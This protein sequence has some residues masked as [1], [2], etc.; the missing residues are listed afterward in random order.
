MSPEARQ[1]EL[2]DPTVPYMTLDI[3]SRVLEL[4]D[5]LPRLSALITE[6]IREL[7]GARFVVLLQFSATNGGAHKA[8]GVNPARRADICD[9]RG[10]GVLVDAVRALD[11]LTVWNVSD[12]VEPVAEALRAL[13]FDLNLAVPLKAGAERVGALL[14]LGVPYEKKMGWIRITINPLS[15]VLSLILRNAFLIQNQ[16]ELINARTAALRV[17]EAEMRKAKEVAEAANR[18]KSEFLATMSH[19]L[20]TPLNAVIG[21]TDLSLGTA[22]NDEQR[23]F[24]Q[25]VYRRSIDLL[26]II[27]DIL[28]LVKIET[29]RLDVVSEEIDVCK[30]VAD[31]VETIELEAKRKNL[32]CHVVIDPGVPAILLGDSLRLKQ[33]LVNLLG[34]AVKF[35][36]KGEIRLAVARRTADLSD[37]GHVS[38]TS[39]TDV[40]LFTVS[41]TGIGIS[42]DKIGLVFDSFYQA[43]SSS[44]RKFG[45]VGLGLA[46]CARLIE[47]MGG[48]I[49]VESEVGKGSVFSFRLPLRPTAAPSS[50]A[51]SDVPG[52]K[53][54]GVVPREDAGGL[55]ILVGEDDPMSVWRVE[56]ILRSSGY[57][58]RSV[59]TGNEALK[60]V[61]AE[62][63][64]AVLLDV[65]LPG[66]SGLDV[67]AAIREMEAAGRLPGASRRRL[68]VIAFTA[69]AMAG[70]RE[71]FL[72]AGMDAYLAKPVVK[73]DLI[74]VLRASVK[75]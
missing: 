15:S 24:L 73:K 43:D 32:S 52:A 41:D 53:P 51:A 36:E 22:L 57:E 59:E 27:S 65:Q 45:G 40:L 2:V 49:L 20:R 42:S 69:F 74:D 13:S 16:E 21:F 62:R 18:A 71:R 60:A 48:R 31:A 35:T 23:G 64:D 30:I 39:S 38:T 50:V 34:N 56:A 66:M 25:I 8:L 29:D 9:T 26:G 37:R 11:E 63:F 3:V 47:K 72:A 14:A 7:T 4:A 12:A 58:L 61:A 1:P 44:S 33:I 54:A 68:P 67:V 28:D 10:F 19:E 46:I 55:R 6:E 17:S 75:G 5:D 70:D